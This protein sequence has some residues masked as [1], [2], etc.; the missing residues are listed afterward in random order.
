MKKLLIFMF[1]IIGIISLYFISDT[2]FLA[3]EIKYE[4]DTVDTKYADENGYMSE[5]K[6]K[7][8]H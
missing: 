5:K 3:K 1:A 6:I 4:F 2:F 7:K 8:K